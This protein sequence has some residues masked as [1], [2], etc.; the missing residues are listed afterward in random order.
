MADETLLTISGM[1]VVPYSARGLTQS[2]TPIA[3]AM[4]MRRTI[5]GNLVDVSLP[6][7]RK[8]SSTISG[9]DQK[10]PAIG[11]VWP[12]KTV[13]VECISELAVSGGSADRTA[14]T[15]STYTE[16]GITYYRPVLTMLVVGYSVETDE[17]G[18]QV[19]WTLALEE[20]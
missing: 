5:N 6:Q 17:Y 11:G 19:G 14:V 13:T 10:S 20:V 7:F 3:S 2:L 8:Y 16:D 4:Q 1:G 15:G 9:R 18:A 12:G